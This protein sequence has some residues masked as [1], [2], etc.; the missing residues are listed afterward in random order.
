MFILPIARSSFPCVLKAAFHSELIPAHAWSLLFQGSSG[1]VKI[2][3]VLHGFEEPKILDWND[4][5]DILS[6]P[7]QHYSLSAE[8]D[9]VHNF[10]KPCSCFAGGDATHIK[11]GFDALLSCDFHVRGR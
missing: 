6:V 7:V 10:C 3:P 9:F 1:A 2:N 8:G 5:G 4:G 11:D